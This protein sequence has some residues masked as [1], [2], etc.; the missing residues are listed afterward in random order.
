MSH[1]WRIRVWPEIN[2]ILIQRRAVPRTA[3]WRYSIQI[4]WR[5][6]ALNSDLTMFSFG[7]RRRGHQCCAANPFN[8][9]WSKI[10]KK[11]LNRSL[12][13]PK[14]HDDIYFFLNGS[15]VKNMLD[16]CGFSY[17]QPDNVF[18]V[19]ESR[20]SDMESQRWYYRGNCIIILYVNLTFYNYSD[21]LKAFVSLNFIVVQLSVSQRLTLW[22][23]I[24]MT[25]YLFVTSL[26]KTENDLFEGS[27]E[28]IHF[29]IHI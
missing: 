18:K 3:I 27:T 29:Y 23:S 15:Q 1:C 25:M 28:K 9:F 4:V 6:T 22:V 14:E 13:F 17:L 2:W 24:N 11:A 7:S 12:F 26:K 16:E 19:N 10:I 21:L 8:H 5:P 20:L